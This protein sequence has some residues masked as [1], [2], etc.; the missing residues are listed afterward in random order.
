MDGRTDQHTDRLSWITPLGTLLCSAMKYAK[1]CKCVTLCAS[2]RLKFNILK[3]WKS[4]KIHFLEH[5]TGLVLMLK[6]KTKSRCLTLQPSQPCLRRAGRRGTAATLSSFDSSSR[7]VGL[8]LC[9]LALPSLTVKHRC[10]DS[11]TVRMD[12]NG[13]WSQIVVQKQL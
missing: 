4:Y 2:V 3:M 8:S 6:L 7:K 10:A 13:T 1:S 11:G 12:K 9:S 5:H